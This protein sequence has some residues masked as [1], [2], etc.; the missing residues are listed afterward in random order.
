MLSSRLHS[1]EI[2]QYR[3]W[4]IISDLKVF[5]TVFIWWQNK[6]LELEIV[7]EKLRQCLHARGHPLYLHKSDF[8][9]ID[10]ESKSCLTLPS[11]FLKKSVNDS[12]PD[13]KKSIFCPISPASQALSC[14][15]VFSSAHP[16]SCGLGSHQ[17]YPYQSQPK[18]NWKPFT[19]AAKKT[20]TEILGCIRLK[21]MRILQN[22]PL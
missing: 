20:F 16:H 19:R 21:D 12:S 7:L 18:A 13:P 22:P 17:Y 8:F 6:T 4:I 10:S 9:C 1:V 14:P 15:R 3:N 2:I 5:Y 11:H